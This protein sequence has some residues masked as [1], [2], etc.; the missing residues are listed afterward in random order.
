M[1]DAD[2]IMLVFKGTPRTTSFSFYWLNPTGLCVTVIVISAAKDTFSAK[3]FSSILF[4]VAPLQ[5]THKL[6]LDVM[7]LFNFWHLA[8]FLAQQKCASSSDSKVT[9]IL[10]CT[11][12]SFLSY[13]TKNLTWSHRSVPVETS[14]WWWRHQSSIFRSFLAHTNC[15]FFFF[16]EISRFVSR[17]C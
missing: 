5:L 13:S 14:Q 2:F 16:C 7:G 11:I 4:F 9:L 3:K 8:I 6:K 10:S 12:L 17:K 1:L 15:L